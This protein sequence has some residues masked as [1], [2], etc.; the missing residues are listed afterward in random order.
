MMLRCCC[1]N[2][3]WITQFVK[4]T[5]PNITWWCCVFLGCLCTPKEWVPDSHSSSSCRKQ[6][7][8]W[9]CEEGSSVNH[10][11]FEVSSW[12]S[13][14]A[15]HK[16]I[17][18]CH[19]MSYGKCLFVCGFVGLIWL[20]VSATSWM[21]QARPS[22]GVG[23]GGTTSN[24]FLPMETVREES[25]TFLAREESYDDLPPPPPPRGPPPVKKA[26]NAGPPP[27]PPKSVPRASQRMESFRTVG[28]EP[29]IYEGISDGV[30]NLSFDYV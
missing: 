23:R 11:R 6:P 9:P 19:M 30:V 27:P 1:Q 16:V 10:R 28:V 7:P 21:R 15:C 20:F 29:Q 24:T 17:F 25:N 4:I 2:W 22:H 26:K 18:G 3:C 8:W 14:C 13:I 12:I 5:S